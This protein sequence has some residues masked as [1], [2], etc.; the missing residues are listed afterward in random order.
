MSDLRQAAQDV[1]AQS[2]HHNP[3]AMYQKIKALEAALAAPQ[4]E[5]VAAVG[6]RLIIVDETFDELM[7]WLERCEDKGHLE[8]C[9]DLIEPWNNFQYT[10]SPQRQPLTDVDIL[11]GWKSANKVMGVPTDQVVLT[12][13]RWL[14]AMHEIGGDK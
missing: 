7:Y 6:K 10:E 13:A 12:F 11:Q 3:D 14:E 2:R 5:P 4:P 9:A 8:N 1:I